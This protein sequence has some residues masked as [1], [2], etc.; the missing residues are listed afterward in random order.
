MHEHVQL[1]KR[2]PSFSWLWLAERESQPRGRAVPGHHGRGVRPK[3]LPIDD[4][5]D[6]GAQDPGP[7]GPDIEASVIIWNRKVHNKDDKSSWGS[8]VSQEKREQFE[9]R[10]QTLLLILKHRFPAIPPVRARHRKDP[11]EQGEQSTSTNMR[12]TQ[13]NAAVRLATDLC[14][15]G[16]NALTHYSRHDRRRR[17]QDVGFALLGSYSRVLESLAFN[18]MSRIEDVVQTDNLARE[19]AKKNAPPDAAARRRTA[20]L[21]FMGWNGD[22]EGKNDDVSPQSHRAAVAGRRH[23]DEAAEHHDQP[24]VDVHGQAGLPLSVNR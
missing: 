2:T 17:Q 16:L 10:A 1:L 5:P 24:Q 6:V 20:L 11:R 23:A 8:A 15:S 22:A 21:H 7:Q 13:Y 14:R 18:V 9:E 4:G 3:R 19:K 12:A